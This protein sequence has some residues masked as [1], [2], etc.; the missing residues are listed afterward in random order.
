MQ[1]SYQKKKKTVITVPGGT[2]VIV[3]TV[4]LFLGVACVLL[5]GGHNVFGRNFHWTQVMSFSFIYIVIL[6]QQVSQ[7]FHNY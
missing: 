2:V 1:F 7:Y 5:D 4:F 6:T 3:V